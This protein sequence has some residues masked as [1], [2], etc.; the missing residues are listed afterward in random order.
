MALIFH[1]ALNART[2]IL[3]IHNY[4]KEPPVVIDRPFFRSFDLKNNNNNWTD[5]EQNKT[6]SHNVI[7]TGVRP[8]TEPTTRRK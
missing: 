6:M 1:V 5:C 4:N 7:E 2:Y 3:K 8:C